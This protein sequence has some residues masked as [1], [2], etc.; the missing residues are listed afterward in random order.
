MS[1]ASLGSEIACWFSKFCSPRQ[2]ELRIYHIEEDDD[3]V[4]PLNFSHNTQG[5]VQVLKNGYLTINRA[6]KGSP[7]LQF[8]SIM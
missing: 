3:V 6:M 1:W 5:A 8:M 4:G 2:V 7:G